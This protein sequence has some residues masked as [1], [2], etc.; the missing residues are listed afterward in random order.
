MTPVNHVFRSHGWVEL[1]N[2]MRF[3]RAWRWTWRWVIVPAILV[4]AFFIA[5]LIGSLK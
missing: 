3:A 2:R 1:D 4:A 5:P